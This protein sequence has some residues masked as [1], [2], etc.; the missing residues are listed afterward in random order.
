MAQDHKQL[1]LLLALADVAMSNAEAVLRHIREQKIGDEHDSY[2]GLVA[3]IVVNYARPFG[4]NRGLGSLP[5]EF[6]EVG[7]F[8]TTDL[9]PAHQY[10]MAMRNQ[11]FAHYDLTKFPKLTKGVSGLRPPDEI[12]LEFEE[13]GFRVT[14]NEI[15]PPLAF[16]GL[17]GQLVLVQRLRISRALHDHL[18]SWIGT[19]PPAGRYKLTPEGL[20]LAKSPDLSRPP[21]CSAK[22]VPPPASTLDLQSDRT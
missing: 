2:P 4:E 20:V 5:N 11:L 7:F 17:I 16:L 10:V 18:I 1:A 3:G 8:G 13:N 12:E 14:T 21:A 9:Q 22:I 19:R 15:R 6:R